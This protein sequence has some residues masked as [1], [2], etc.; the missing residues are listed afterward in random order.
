LPDEER[1]HFSGF[2]ADMMPGGGY[3]DIDRLLAVADSSALSPFSQRLARVEGESLDDEVLRLD[4][5]IEWADENASV[6]AENLG[7]SRALLIESLASLRDTLDL[8]AEVVRQ[9]EGSPDPVRWYQKSAERERSMCRRMDWLV[10]Q[11]GPT[12]KVV[13]CG[14]NEHVSKD[15]RALWLGRAGDPEIPPPLTLGHYLNERYPGEVCSIWLL[16][17]H[18]QHYPHPMDPHKREDVESDPARLEH[19]LAEIGQAYM[20]PLQTDDSR[21]ELLDQ[22]WDYW[23]GAAAHRCIPRRQADVIFFLREVGQPRARDVDGS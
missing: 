4:A 18:G 7:D 21:A 2:D 14:H 16:F 9:F 3:E 12:E 22:K 8:R 11:I 17:D 20:L 6:L 5:A 15:E 23:T 10:D 13:L 1:L 19:V